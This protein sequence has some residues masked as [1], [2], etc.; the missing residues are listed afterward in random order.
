MTT[1]A[2]WPKLSRPELIDLARRILHG[3]GTEEQIDEWANRFDAAVLMPNASA[4]LL[5]PDHYQ[6]TGVD[7]ATYEPT[8]EEVVDRVL[9]HR[10]IILGPGNEPGSAREP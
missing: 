1:E 9:A 5:W 3:E 8:P 10:S 6:P 4:L 7:P 2:T